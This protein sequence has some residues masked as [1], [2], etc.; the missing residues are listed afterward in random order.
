MKMKRYNDSKKRDKEKIK[1]K[2]ENR[3]N[4]EL[5]GRTTRNV[6]LTNG[7]K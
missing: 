1:Q 2:K 7:S 6:K 5:G 4:Y 3:K